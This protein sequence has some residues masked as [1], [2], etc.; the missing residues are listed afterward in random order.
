MAVNLQVA[1]TKHRPTQPSDESPGCPEF[2]C[3]PA[4]PAME[5]R[6]A[7][8]LAS[9]SGSVNEDPGCPVSSLLQLRLRLSFRVAPSPQSS[10]LSG[11]GAS[12]CLDSRIFQR[13]CERSF[14]LPR[15]L[16]SPAPP[17]MRLRVAPKPAPSGL[18]TVRVF[19]SPRI[20]SPS[21]LALGSP[22]GSPRL[23][24]PVACLGISLWVAPNP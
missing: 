4:V 7:S 16:A 24:R 13:L 20:L 10:G 22:S 5:P 18:P 1:W 11:D 6:V 14:R 2:P 21:G 8:T 9:F 19:R 15:L 3:L 17:S 12:S 23:P